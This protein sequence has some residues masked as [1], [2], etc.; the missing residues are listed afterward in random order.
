MDA[1]HLSLFDTRLILAAYDTNTDYHMS[2]SDD[3]RA[4]RAELVKIRAGATE[5]VQEAKS[6]AMSGAAELKKLKDETAAMQAELA[7]LTNGGPPLDEP[8]GPTTILP[9]VNP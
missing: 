8:V 6:V 3:I 7:G 1:I 2:I 9:P 4:A 5:A